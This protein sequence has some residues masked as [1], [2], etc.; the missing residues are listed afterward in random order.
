[1][2][3]YKLTALQLTIKSNW[4][5]FAK[6]SVRMV[7]VST[8]FIVFMVYETVVIERKIDLVL[9]L[10]HIFSFIVIIKKN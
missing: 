5:Q 7:V 10:P 9:T 1:M 4:T 6:N 8:V 3:L 2:E